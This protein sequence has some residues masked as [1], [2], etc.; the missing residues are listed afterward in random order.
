MAFA[1]I[2]EI[3][4]DSVA[5][6][7]EI[8]PASFFEN[9]RSVDSKDGAVFR[10]NVGEVRFF[11]DR[12]AVT[13]LIIGPFTKRARASGPDAQYMEGMKF[14]A[15]WKR[16]VELRPVKAFRQLTASVTEPPDVFWPVMG[17]PMKLIG[18]RADG[19]QRSGIAVISRRSEATLAVGFSRK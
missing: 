5:I 2:G 4:G 13:L 18:F 7:G 15:E 3:N 11:P 14:K 8:G 19:D 9:L 6:R 17:I 16:G 1:G 12:V 10:N